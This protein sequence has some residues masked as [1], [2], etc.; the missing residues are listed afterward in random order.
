MKLS[1]LEI[2]GNGKRVY[3]D[4]WDKHFSSLES[5]ITNR[6]TDLFGHGITSG[7]SVTILGGGVIRLSD[8]TAYNKDGQRIQTQETELTPPEGQSKLLLQHTFLTEFSEPDFSQSSREYRN[9]S[10]SIVFTSEVLGEY[11]VPL[12]SLQR[13]GNTVTVLEDLRQWQTIQNKNLGDGIKI[14]DLANLRNRILSAIPQEALDLITA[15]N[16]IDEWLQGHAENTGNPHNVGLSQLTNFSAGSNR[17]QSVASGTVATDAVNKGQLDSEA[18]ARQTADSGLQSAI[19]AEASA[20]QTEDGVLQNAIN[21]E[22]SA[23]QGGDTNLQTA[24]DGKAAV[25]HG[26]SPSEVGLGNVKNFEQVINKSSPNNQIALEWNGSNLIADID[27]GGVSFP[28]SGSL[29]INIIDQPVI[30]IFNFTVNPTA[31]SHLIGYGFRMSDQIYLS[32]S[33]IINGYKNHNNGVSATSIIDVPV[34][35][36]LTGLGLPANS[37]SLNTGYGVSSSN[38]ANAFHQRG[39]VLPNNNF[40]RIIL[41]DGDYNKGCSV[42]FS[43]NITLVVN[44]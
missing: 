41:V 16:K 1:G 6:N 36:I 32:L 42:Y 35:S 38:I 28:V 12:F 11:D 25:S 31:F 2:P 8:T 3:K 4:D 44:N 33:G 19:N 7:G 39:W 13:V 30:G 17:I 21:A 18:S 24:I 27:N 9:N 34:N 10:Y 37:Y 26:H 14:G 5:E 15:V 43:C 23:R 40:L 29:F 22:A 20:R